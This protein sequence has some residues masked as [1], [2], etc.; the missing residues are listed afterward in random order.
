MGWGFREMRNHAK[1]I[2]MRTASG[3]HCV[4]TSSNLNENPRVE[5][6]TWDNDEETWAFYRSLFDAVFG[7]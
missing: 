5:T 6:Y 7:R 1:L 3:F 4:R 2:L